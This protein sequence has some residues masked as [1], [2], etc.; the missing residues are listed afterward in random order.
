MTFARVFYWWVYFLTFSDVLFCPKSSDTL[1][2]NM[3]FETIFTSLTKNLKLIISKNDSKKFYLLK[4]EP[5]L[6]PINS[7]K[8]IFYKSNLENPSAFKISPNGPH[9]CA[10]KYVAH[11][12]I[13][14]RQIDFPSYSYKKW[15]LKLMLCFLI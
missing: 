8:S 9:I 12:G 15:T 1:L 11:L 14:W 5:C 2:C 13:F 3:T 6:L 4:I 10:R 7:L